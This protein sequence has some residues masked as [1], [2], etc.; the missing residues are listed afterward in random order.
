MYKMNREQTEGKVQ[1]RVQVSGINQFFTYLYIERLHSLFVDLKAFELRLT[2]CVGHIRAK[3]RKWRLLLVAVCLW[4]VVSLWVWWKDDTVYVSYLDMLIVHWNLTLSLTALFLLY[5][6]GIFD[7][8]NAP[9][10]Y[11]SVK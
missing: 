7:R 8:N 10:V 11:P 5:I 4:V 1:A 9:N 3:T 6:F 2:E